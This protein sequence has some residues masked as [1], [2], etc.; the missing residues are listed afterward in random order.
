MERPPKELEQQ[1]DEREERREPIPRARRGV[2]DATRVEAAARRF[3]QEARSDVYNP[4]C[5]QE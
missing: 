1:R 5:G 4:G 2:G 3:T